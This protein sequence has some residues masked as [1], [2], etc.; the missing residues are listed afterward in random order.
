MPRRRTKLFL[1]FTIF[2]LVYI[3]WTDE[4]KSSTKPELLDYCPFSTSTH[5]IPT[6]ILVGDGQSQ[7]LQNRTFHVA[8]STDGLP[9]EFLPKKVPT[10]DMRFSQQLNR[11]ESKGKKVKPNRAEEGVQTCQIHRVPSSTLKELPKDWLPSKMMF[12]MSTTPDRVLYSIPVWQ[13]WLPSLSQSQQPRTSEIFD[14]AT[15][16]EK[17]QLPML[18]ILS[19]PGDSGTDT[20]RMKESM[21]EA[22]GRG[23]YVTMRELEAERFEKR[24]FLLAKEMA[25]EAEKREVE[26]GVETEWFIFASVSQVS[27][28][29]SMA[30]TL[31]MSQRRR[32]FLPRFE[33]N[34]AHVVKV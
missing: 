1:S 22:R 31:V 9:V 19:P 14:E 6:V 2:T 7:P 30:L 21:D 20:A 28:P 13:H 3:Y 16:E 34:C 26:T 11:V 23:M 29:I 10:R 25:E 32:Y 33:P 18:L 24:Y 8:D 4:S 12:G 5:H 15:Q 17:N 27:I